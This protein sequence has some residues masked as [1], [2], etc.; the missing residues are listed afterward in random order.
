MLRKTISK[1]LVLFL[2]FTLLIFSFF[3]NAGLLPKTP[4]KLVSRY[5][6]V[7]VVKKVLPR[8]IKNYG[9]RAGG[10]AEDLAI[11]FIKKN[12]KKQKEVFDSIDDYVRA[13]PLYAKNASLLKNKLKDVT[14]N[15]SRDGM[16]IPKNGT[17]S[18]DY[19]NSQFWPKTIDTNVV[20]KYK[21]SD[22]QKLVGK[23]GIPFKN[24]YP[25][26]TKYRKLSVKVDGM[27]GKTGPDKKKAYEQLV[28]DKVFK[29]VKEGKEFAKKH[30]LAVHHEPD[31]VTMSF[32][33]RIIHETIRHEGGAKILRTLNPWLQ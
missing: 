33:P 25:D 12:P 24:G 20:T 22:L 29:S 28:D 19:G 9:K 8:L 1:F 26:F 5:V 27:V 7:K 32:V 13:N 4:T 2:S 21:M 18:G 14:P 31:G 17:W 3:A 10:H 30:D 16:H 6:T 11:N 23:D 15:L